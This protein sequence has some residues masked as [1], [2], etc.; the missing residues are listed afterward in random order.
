MKERNAKKAEREFDKIFEK[1]RKG[2]KDAEIQI[3][4]KHI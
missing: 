4:Q 1:I 2:K 3:K